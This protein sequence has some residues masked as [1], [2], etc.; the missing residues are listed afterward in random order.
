ME[1]AQTATG[2]NHDVSLELGKAADYAQY[3][4]SVIADMKRR[5]DQGKVTLSAAEAEAFS[6]ML[7]DISSEIQEANG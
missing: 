3:L 5:D 7:A 1:K 2:N 4:H 6:W